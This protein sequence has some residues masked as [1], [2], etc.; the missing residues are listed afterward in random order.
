MATRTRTLLAGVAT[1]DNGYHTTLNYESEDGD[2]WIVGGTLEV[3]PTA[4]VIGIS[5][6]GTTDFNQLQN[7]P[8]YHGSPMTGDVDIPTVPT[9]LSELENDADYVTTND[10]AW[11]SK[12]DTLTAGNG[13]SLTEDVLAVKLSTDADNSITFGT[14]N[15][16]YVPVG[17]NFDEI[18]GGTF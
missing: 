12:L 17:T 16:L 4:T 14:D 3:L 7:R 11:H 1:P 2:K 18:N 13:I 8:S 15:G 10:S 5:G 6:V 9:K